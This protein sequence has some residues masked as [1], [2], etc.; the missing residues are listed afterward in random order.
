[1]VDDIIN[2]GVFWLTLAQKTLPLFQ[3]LFQR[4]FWHF[5]KFLHACHDAVV[6]FN[7]Y[8]RRGL[9][10]KDIYKGANG[11]YVATPEEFVKKFGGDRPINKV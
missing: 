1:M 3:S 4:Q 11:H 6:L 7:A 5:I 8:R 2:V 10:G 9:S